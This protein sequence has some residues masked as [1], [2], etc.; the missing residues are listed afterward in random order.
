[1]YCTA[2][3]DFGCLSSLSFAFLAEGFLMLSEA[4]ASHKF[5]TNGTPFSPTCQRKFVSVVRKEILLLQSSLPSGILIRGFENAMVSC[6]KIGEKCSG[7]GWE[8]L[9]IV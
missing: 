2:L 7:S 5:N 8:K 9:I 4:P 3:L 6:V 1:M